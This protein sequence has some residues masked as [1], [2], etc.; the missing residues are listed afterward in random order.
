MRR[1]TILLEY[2]VPLRIR[3][4]EPG[5]NVLVKQHL[6]AVSGDLFTVQHENDRTLFAI[7]GYDTE[8]HHPHRRLTERADLV[9]VIDFG[10]WQ[11]C[12]IPAVASVHQGIGGEEFFVRKKHTHF[13]G[14]LLQS[15]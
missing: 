13:A 5:N 15:P 11:V 3:G 14:D 12:K 9:T 1:R 6:V 10:H 8:D 2:I 4:R 7:A